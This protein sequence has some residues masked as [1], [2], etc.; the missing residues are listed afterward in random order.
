MVEIKISWQTAVHGSKLFLWWET[1][2]ISFRLT[3]LV[4]WKRLPLCQLG[5]PG[6]RENRVDP[7]ETYDITTTKTY[8]EYF[9]G[10]TLGIWPRLI[11]TGPKTVVRSSY[12]YNEDSYTT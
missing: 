7:D 6:E 12:V 4:L 1:G 2:Q 10:T 5:N 8:R 3:S 11:G 9:T